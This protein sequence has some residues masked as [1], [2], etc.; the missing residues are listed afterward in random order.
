LVVT[1]NHWHQGTIDQYENDTSG[2]YAHGTATGQT[3][4]TLR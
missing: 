3:T 4:V 2:A 1:V